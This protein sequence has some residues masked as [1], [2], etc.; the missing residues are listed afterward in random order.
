MIN[1]MFNY[2]IFDVFYLMRNTYMVYHVTFHM[3][4]QIYEIKHMI[5]GILNSFITLYDLSHQHLQ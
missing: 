5:N 3:L 1:Y 4:Y 2:V